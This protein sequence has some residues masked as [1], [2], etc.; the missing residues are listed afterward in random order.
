MLNYAVGDI[1]H[2]RI[3]GDIKIYTGKIIE[4]RNDGPRLKIVGD[5]EEA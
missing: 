4:I 1:Y 5:A 2:L 3:T